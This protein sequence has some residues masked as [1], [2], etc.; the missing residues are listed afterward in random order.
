MLGTSVDKTFNWKVIQ[1][2]VDFFEKKTKCV[3]IIEDEK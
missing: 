2:R 1:S 3:P